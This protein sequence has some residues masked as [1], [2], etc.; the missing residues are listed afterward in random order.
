MKN[1]TFY[2]VVNQDFEPLSKGPSARTFQADGDAEK[3]AT[4]HARHHAGFAFYV[5][6]ATKK[7]VVN[8]ISK[9]D[10]K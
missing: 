6:K 3:A 8:G 2:I 10:L 9:V 7:C 1:K 4:S 5:M